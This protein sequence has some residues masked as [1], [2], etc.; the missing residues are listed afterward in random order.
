MMLRMSAMLP[1]RLP[2]TRS[3]TFGGME[4][5]PK[6]VAAAANGRIAR[7]ERKVGGYVTDCFKHQLAIEFNDASAIDSGP[8]TRC[9]TRPPWHDGHVIGPGA[10]R[11]EKI[12]TRNPPTVQP[13]CS[14]TA[15]RIQ[16][17]NRS[18]LRFNDVPGLIDKVFLLLC[19]DRPLPWHKNYDRG[20]LIIT[21]FLDGPYRFHQIFESLFLLR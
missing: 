16:L 7:F 5:S 9:Q 6:L 10:P 8:R 1:A 14:T 3:C 4:T 13:R 2:F 20:P 18:I 21:Y 15:G 12:P 17:S 11:K 19:L